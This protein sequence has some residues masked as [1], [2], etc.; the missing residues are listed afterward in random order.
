MFFWKDLLGNLGC[1]WIAEVMI[2]RPHG[3][4]N[5]VGIPSCSSSNSVARGR[6]SQCLDGAGH[7]ELC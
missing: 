5:F 7:E 4:P 3:R 2:C 1:V 6:N